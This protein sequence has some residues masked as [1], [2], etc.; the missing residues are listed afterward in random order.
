MARDLADAFPE[1]KRALEQ[2]DQALGLPLTHV[3]F[4]GP[5]EILT[6]THNAQPALLAH[7]AA[8]WAVVRERVQRFVRATAGH[9]LGEH[10]AYHAAGA[11]ALPEAV[12]LVRARGELMHDAGVANPGTMAAILGELSRSVDD[13]CAEASATAGRVVPANYNSPEQTVIS[14][15]I[16]AVERAMELAKSAG[17]KRVVRLAVAGAFHSPLMAQAAQGL[18]TAI[19]SAHFSDPEFPVYSNVTA[20]P[21]STAADAKDMLRRQL[22][23]PVRW[24]ELVRNMAAAFPAALYVEMGPGAVLSGLV[25]RIVKGARTLACGTATEIEKLLQLANS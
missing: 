23:S 11:V 21:V 25:S 14:G 12:R 13:I 8:V 19:G 4:E 17:A 18:G 10:T 16:A 22:T 1:A 5:A 15:E 24:A 2:V 6:A 9:S 20:M 3:M 7:G